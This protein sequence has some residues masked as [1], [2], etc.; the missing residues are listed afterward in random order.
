MTLRQACATWLVLFALAVAAGPAVATDP[1]ERVGTHPLPILEHPQGPRNF[2]MGW[3]G[4]ADASTPINVFYNPANIAFLDRFHW[5]AS[6]LDGTSDIDFFDFGVFGGREFPLSDGRSWYLAGSVRYSREDFEWEV[7]SPFLPDLGTIEYDAWALP[8][9]IAAG[10]SIPHLDIGV[11]TT[12]K[13]AASESGDRELD[14]TAYDIGALARTKIEPSESI[15]LDIAGGV[16]V[17]NLGEV[18]GGNFDYDLTD[19]YH[20]GVGVG[21]SGY[22]GDAPRTA[23]LWR[24]NGNLDFIDSD[25]DEDFAYGVEI[26][27]FDTAFLRAGHRGDELMNPGDYWG[28]GLAHRIKSVALSADFAQSPETISLT[29]DNRAECYSVSGSFEF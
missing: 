18:T 28:L 6:F 25:Y 17:V 10:L 15:D 27:V 9:S 26:G 22:R 23:A 3:T 21:L 7:S 16:S 5:N 14:A 13:F 1:F 12:V 4:A 19:E 8:L 24:L 11:G 29:D 20:W 2:A